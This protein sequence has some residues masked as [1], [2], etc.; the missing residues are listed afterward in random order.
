MEKSVY[1]SKWG[2]HRFG[3]VQAASKQ[4][5]FMRCL[6]NSRIDRVVIYQRLVK[7]VFV[8]WGKHKIYLALDSSI[9]WDEF[10][11]VRVA[12][13][14][15]ERALPLGWVVLKQ[16]STM[17]AFEKYAPI[18]KDTDAPARLGLVLATAT[19]YL[20]ST[21]TAVVTPG[22]AFSLGSILIGNASSV[23][24]KSVGARS[25]MHS[26]IQLIC[27]LSSCLNLVLILSLLLLQNARLPDSSSLST[28]SSWRLCK[29]F[30]SIRFA[31]SNLKINLLR[32]LFVKRWAD[33]H[34]RYHNLTAPSVSI[35]FGP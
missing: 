17:V 13:V 23:P 29:I 5:Q 9:L 18:M 1:V 3:E 25:T 26:L 35:A 30:Q 12:L 32:R 21:D 33:L 2:A 8:G 15:R 27:H 19:I 31:I 11:I 4:R 24:S 14:Y 16:K 22:F 10:V 7:S 20:V 34:E 28:N 6:K